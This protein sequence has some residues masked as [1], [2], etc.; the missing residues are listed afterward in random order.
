MRAT[1]VAAVIAL[2]FGG[3]AVGPAGG[4]EGTPAAETLEFELAPGVYA[5]IL[6]VPEDP[7]ALYRLRFDA[8]VSFPVTAEPVF[9]LVLVESG[10]LTLRLGTPVSVARAADPGSAA[11]S[12]DA[13]TEFTAA[14]GDYF[15]IPPQAAGEV[16]NEADEPATIAVAS[17]IPG[18]AA[19]ATPEP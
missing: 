5:S 2:I 15:V 17:L 18:G 10:E 16:R 7:P 12:I 8:G 9:N 6:P 14:Q 19:A 1:I 11:E 3:L 13:D 4:Q